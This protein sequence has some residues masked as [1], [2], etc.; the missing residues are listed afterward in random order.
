M[1]P[2]IKLQNSL[3]P[4]DFHMS[5]VPYLAG[6]EKI[7]ED[8]KKGIDFDLNTIMQRILIIV[9]V[10]MLFLLGDLFRLIA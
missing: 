4:K 7:P 6:Y 3:S 10:S 2:I 9:C 1:E 8:L 5:M